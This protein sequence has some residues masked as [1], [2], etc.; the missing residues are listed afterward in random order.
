MKTFKHLGKLGDVVWAL[1]FIKEMGGAETIYFS[2][3]DLKDFT[4]KD[5]EF[6]KPLLEFQSYIKDVKIWEQESIDFDLSNF[7][8]PLQAFG[9]NIL[10]SF[11][12]LYL[13]PV[14]NKYTFEPWLECPAV[15]QTNN[16][17]VSYKKFEMTDWEKM[18]V[19]HN[20]YLNLLNKN[21]ETTGLF[22][23]TEEEHH[24]FNQTYRC[25]ITH[26]KV[27]NA[28]ELA[29]LIKSSS[30]CV[31]NQSFP[32][33]LAESLKKSLFLETWR[34]SKEHLFLRPNL[35]STN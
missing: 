8:Q 31:G 3:N 26:K 7:H 34:G 16:I 4:I 21:L 25:N 27:K 33:V 18:F 11:F 22:V 17:I 29:C 1:P 30:M 14:P 13:K 12:D 24:S 15:E 23:G 10:S 35:I 9:G 19:P 20:F 28:L 32:T 6:I 5:I 2:E